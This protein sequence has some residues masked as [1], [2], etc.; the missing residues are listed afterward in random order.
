MPTKTSSSDFLEGLLDENLT[1]LLDDM[2]TRDIQRFA[3]ESPSTLETP[4]FGDVLPLHTSLVSGQPIAQ[5]PTS[6]QKSYRDTGAPLAY[7]GSGETSKKQCKRAAPVIGS[8]GPRACY[9]QTT[10]YNVVA[11]FRRNQ[12][13][14]RM[15][16]SAAYSSGPHNKEG[17]GAPGEEQ[18]GPEEI[19]RAQKGKTSLLVSH[20]VGNSERQVGNFVR[21]RNILQD[22]T[23]PC[24]AS[25]I[26]QNFQV[27]EISLVQT[28]A[29]ERL[30]RPSTVRP[31]AMQQMDHVDLPDGPRTL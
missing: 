8:E 7:R 23:R 1:A 27:R 31:C 18:K 17:K 14:R 15:L 30:G 2:V 28:A 25:F 22:A 6:D 19:Q 20:T 9:L 4:S 12:S 10:H 16:H 5:F 3:G 13:Q 29:E 26:V 24:T 21:P 11:C